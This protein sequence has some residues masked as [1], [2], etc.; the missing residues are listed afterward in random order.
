MTHHYIVTGSSEGLGAELSK[1]LLKSDN[2]VFGISRRGNTE[3]DQNSNFVNYQADV[4]NEAQISSVLNE[5]LHKYEKIDGVVHAAAVS[6]PLGRIEDTVSIEWIEAININLIGTYNLIRKCANYFREQKTGNFVAISGGG[7][8]S[9]MPRMTAYAA[10]KT[11]IVRLVESVARDFD[12]YSKVTFNTVA[13]GIMKTKM[14]NKVIDAGPEIV[15]QAY[16]EQIKD[17]K[18]NGNDSIPK[19]V[20]L[21]KFLVTNKNHG[22]SGKLIS[23]VWDDWKQLANDIEYKEN[24]EIHTLRRT[25]NG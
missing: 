6:G 22:I 8:T 23:A 7:A 17:F 3:L 13:P 4:S 9:P 2:L 25:L 5:I 10:S 1:N 11:A 18:I 16:F 24:L 15:G 21:I 12:D 20:D 19:A 14:I